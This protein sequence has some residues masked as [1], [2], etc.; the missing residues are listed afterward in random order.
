MSY[1]PLK[2]NTEK[3]DDKYLK[4]YDRIYNRYYTRAKR[5]NYA[6][7]TNAR[8]K[9]EYSFDNFFEWSQRA[10]DARKCYLFWR[11]IG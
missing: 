7:L 6:D 2:F 5:F 3:E 10:S 8:A 1:K 11:N 9:I 4:E